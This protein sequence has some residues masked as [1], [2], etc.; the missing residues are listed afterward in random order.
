MV[1]TVFPRLGAQVQ[2]LVRDLRSHRPCKMVKIKKKKK[3]TK[4]SVG[5][6]GKHKQK[7][8]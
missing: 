2:S 6:V 8:S 4:K 1:K 5:E 7:E 3:T